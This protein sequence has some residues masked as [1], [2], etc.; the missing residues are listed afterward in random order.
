MCGTG[1]VSKWHQLEDVGHS[2]R[3][4]ESTFLSFYPLP[5]QVGTPEASIF[6]G[7]PYSIAGVHS[8][9]DVQACAV[10]SK[11]RRDR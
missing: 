3:F 10:A 9:M 4:A 6:G 1:V 11:P 8:H 5:S 2:G 7:E